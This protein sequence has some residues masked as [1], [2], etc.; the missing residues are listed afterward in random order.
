VLP[1]SAPP[2]LNCQGC[3]FII[4]CSLFT[5]HYSLFIVHYSLFIVLC[6]QEARS[7]FRQA[8][9]RPSTA[10]QYFFRLSAV[11]SYP[12]SAELFSEWQTSIQQI[13]SQFLNR[14]KQRHGS[15]VFIKSFQRCL[16][17]ND[18]GYHHLQGYSVQLPFCPSLTMCEISY[19]MLLLYRLTL[20]GIFVTVVLM[21]AYHFVLTLSF[22]KY[23][24]VFWGNPTD[25]GH[26]AWY[27]KTQ[28]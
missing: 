11:F 12:F 14:M 25:I 27:I 7:V 19:R 20:T 15:F 9:Q 2:A 16:V 24:C 23:P 8:F 17:R 10:F 18:A 3:L 28:T 6:I 13:L 26:L 4:H 22:Y 21:L 1:H 5:V